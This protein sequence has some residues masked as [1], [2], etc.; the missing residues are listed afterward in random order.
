MQ[1]P[2]LQWRTRK[3]IKDL[4]GETMIAR[5]GRK[6]NTENYIKLSS[7]NF[8]SAESFFFPL[9]LLQSQR[10]VMFNLREY[11]THNISCSS[12][13]SGFEGSQLYAGHWSSS[14]PNRKWLVSYNDALLGWYMVQLRSLKTS[15][16]QEM[17]LTRCLP[18][19]EIMGK[20]KCSSWEVF[21]CTTRYA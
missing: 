20:L 8:L 3:I 4:T 19:H 16:N 21:N 13:K 5:T 6:W 15:P 12:S 18:S 7:S 14:T 2:Q 9:G 1:L 11:L 10:S 17:S